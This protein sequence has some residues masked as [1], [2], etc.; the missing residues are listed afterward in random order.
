M[1]YALNIINCIQKISIKF[2]QIIFTKQ[3][4][5]E[6]VA[7]FFLTE[8]YGRS[9]NHLWRL[10]S[11]CPQLAARGPHFVRTASGIAPSATASAYKSPLTLPKTSTSAGS[12]FTLSSFSAESQAAFS[13]SKSVSFPETT[14]HK[15]HSIFK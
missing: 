2:F 10:P 4:C 1:F 5:I 3:L 12:H 15:K 8:Y 13:C 11:L 14:E 9:G 6:K 7:A